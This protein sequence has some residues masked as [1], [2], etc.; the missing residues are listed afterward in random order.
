MELKVETLEGGVRCV[1]LSGRLDL[2]G[3]Q[4]VEKE[5]TAQ[6]AGLKQS[7]IVDMSKVEY[8]ASIGI[9]LLLSN[10][11][12]LTAAKAR[13]VILK[14]QQMVDDVLKMAGLDAVIPI[15]YDVATA[16]EML[17]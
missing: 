8:I 5:F 7:V 9:R 2:K 3:T 14:P 15:E 1:H 12:G 17:K 13:M 4:G 10:V 11:K 6:V 16:L